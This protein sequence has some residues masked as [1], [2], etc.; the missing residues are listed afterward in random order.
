M[1]ID[2]ASVMCCEELKEVCHR[3]G[4]FL[5]LGVKHCQIVTLNREVLFRFV[6]FRFDSIFCHTVGGC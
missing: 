4:E 6:L 5:K 3:E 1:A 2:I